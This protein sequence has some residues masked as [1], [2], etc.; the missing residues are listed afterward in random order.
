MD[1]GG[2]PLANE[3]GT[4]WVSFN[5]ELYNDPTLRKRLLDAGHTDDARLGYM[6]HGVDMFT[7]PAL[8]ELGVDEPPEQGAVL[9]T[10]PL[11]KL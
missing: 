3:D 8:A 1:G 7:T 2:Q 11:P 4:V 9:P 10:R 5:G 6:G